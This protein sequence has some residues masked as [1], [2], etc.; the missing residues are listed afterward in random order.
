MSVANADIRDIPCKTGSAIAGIVL[1]NSFDV[2]RVAAD[3]RHHYQN[4]FTSQILVARQ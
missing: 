1:E 2:G 4:I 3:F